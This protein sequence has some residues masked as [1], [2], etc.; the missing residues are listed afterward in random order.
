MG[1]VDLVAPA[2]VKILH[3][4]EPSA[5]VTSSA[6]GIPL[7]NVGQLLVFLWRV[8]RIDPT[9]ISMV[10]LCYEDPGAESISVSQSWHYWHR[11]VL[12]SRPPVLH[13]VLTV[14]VKY[15]EL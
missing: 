6:A 5:T 10:Q 2:I 11:L 7:E 9:V 12:D 4:H 3:G 8:S 15:N 13:I 14:Q 1:R